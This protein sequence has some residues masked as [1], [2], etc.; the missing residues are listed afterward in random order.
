MT[1]LLTA[2]IDRAYTS[3]L[4]YRQ[5]L[6]LR[7]PTVEIVE[8]LVQLS[9]EAGRGLAESNTSSRHAHRPAL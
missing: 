7:R 3:R 5:D 9:P 2:P 1:V 4:S 8:H 6:W